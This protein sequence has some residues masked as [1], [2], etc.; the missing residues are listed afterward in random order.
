MRRKCGS[1]PLKPRSRRAGTSLF[2]KEAFISS[3]FIRLANAAYQPRRTLC[4][5]GCMRLLA[6]Q[7]VVI[8][9][10]ADP[11]SHKAVGGFDREGPMVTSDPSGPEATDLLEM[12]GRV[13]RVLFQVREGPIGEL[14]DLGRQ[15][16]IVG[17]EIG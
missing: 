14:L 1:D 2:F 7:P 3:R 16:S 8:C 5:V 11:E 13:T 6:K 10:V 15:R 17:P 4:A 9:M 12:K